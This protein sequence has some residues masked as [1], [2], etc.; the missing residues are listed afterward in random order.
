MFARRTGWV[1]EKNALTREVDQRRERGL[2]VI[3][4]TESNPTRCGFRYN[5]G[6]ILQA[7]ANPAALAYSPQ[8]R[9]ALEA[10]RAVAEYYAGRGVELDPEQVFLTS[11][12]SEAYSR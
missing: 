5:S 10:R 6:A 9:G 4:L 12:T 7:L 11:S 2:A 8:P 3:D 1:L